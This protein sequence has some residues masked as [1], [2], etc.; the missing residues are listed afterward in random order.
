MAATKHSLRDTWRLHERRFD[1]TG[2]KKICP[3]LHPFARF[4]R[5][6]GE[7]HGSR[8]TEEQP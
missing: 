5:I 3:C 2:P 1:P 4:H 6:H 7:R 8:S